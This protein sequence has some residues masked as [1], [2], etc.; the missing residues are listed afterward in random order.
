MASAVDVMMD[1]D[2][3]SAAG[4]DG[5]DSSCVSGG[6][7][8]GSLQALRQWGARAGYRRAQDHP[9]GH[10]DAS[11]G[12]WAAAGGGAHA[13]DARPGMRH[14]WWWCSLVPSRRVSGRA[15]G[16]Y[17]W[18]AGTSYVQWTPPFGFTTSPGRYLNSLQG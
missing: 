6:P 15:P 14:G 17:W 18:R 12:P 7:A 3:V 11:P 13:S 8:R 5:S 1:V 10:P 2:G 4:R 16:V 9:R